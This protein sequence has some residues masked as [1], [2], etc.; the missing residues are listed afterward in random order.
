MITTIH[1]NIDIPIVG[2]SKNHPRRKN[3]AVAKM[4]RA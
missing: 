3:V 4:R 1:I 2:T